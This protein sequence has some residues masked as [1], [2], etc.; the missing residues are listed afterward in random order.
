M[1]D[2]T[3]P[4][5]KKGFKNLFTR[6]FLVIIG[7]ILITGLVMGVALGISFYR[8]INTSQTELLSANAKSVAS[9]LTA[10]NRERV[11]L[12]DAGVEQV[13]TGTLSLLSSNLTADVFI[14]DDDGQVVICRHGSRGAS[15]L[16]DCGHYGGFSVPADM[17]ESAA[18]G[19][20]YSGRTRLSGAL[21][22]EEIAVVVPVVMPDSPVAAGYVCALQ[23]LSD[24]FSPF[25]GDFVRI[26]ILCGIF[27][28]ALACMGV[29]VLTYNIVHPLRE[30][31]RATQSY[32][33]G[34][35][36]YRVPV[37][38]NDE[39]TELE[40]GFNAMARDLGILEASRRSFVANVSHEL[41]TPMTTIGG[42]IDGI[43]DGTIPKEKEAY[44][45]GVVSDEVKRL[46]RLV[47]TM[48]NMSK[49]ESGELR[50]NPRRYDISRQIFQVMLNFERAL[51]DKKVEVAGL[52]RMDSVFVEAD[53]DLIH[54]VI[55]NLVDNAVKFTPEH[56]C[57][58]VSAIADNTRVIVAIR[59]SGEGIPPDELSRVFERFYKVDKSRSIDAKGAGL[60]L[61]IVKSIVEL[62]GGQIA[63]KSEMGQYTEFAFWLPANFSGQ[64]GA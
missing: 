23:D 15:R 9:S 51:D 28:L 25:L 11:D 10:L 48:L 58:S 54:Q 37:T 43:R 59:N 7:I 5:E 20:E 13:M 31:A 64:S 21:K 2:R 40:E 39:L 50:L 1:G 6:Y 49:I 3:D 8:Y 61:Y 16:P 22:D 46:S 35:F 36:T 17:L 24:M 63:V 38:G 4:A 44:Y 42:F 12:D 41:K 52:D 62:H 47:V 53:Q 27:V 32:A 29:Y 56:G 60:G 14:C 30:M 19:G 34:D 26:F 18:A 57:I 33:K 45:L 55:Y